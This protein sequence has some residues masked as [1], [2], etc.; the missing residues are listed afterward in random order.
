LLPDKDF[1]T[2]REFAHKV[3]SHVSYVQKALRKKIIQGQQDDK[4]RWFIPH[5]EIERWFAYA[6]NSCSTNLKD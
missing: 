3:D 5:S 2:T 1:Y 6:T 4:K